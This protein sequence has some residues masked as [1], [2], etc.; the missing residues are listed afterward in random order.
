MGKLKNKNLIVI[1]GLD[2]SGKKTQANL[3]VDNLNSVGKKAVS[4][5]FPVYGSDTS[6]LLKRHLNEGLGKENT[7][8]VSS[9]FALDRYF[10]FTVNLNNKYKDF[11]FIVA[12]RYT[13]SNA[14]YQTAKFRPDSYPRYLSWLFDYEYQKIKNPEPDLVILLAIPLK[15]SGE[16]LLKRYDDDESKKDLYEKDTKYLRLCQK[17]SHSLAIKY[18]WKIVPCF[19]VKNNNLLTPAEISFNVFDTVK[20]YFR[21]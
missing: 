5:S 11:D 3:L 7:Y 12:D 1:E 15:V 9:L 20:D 17:I 18:K 6:S 16:L 2:G 10:N 19:D 8:A 4:I 14:M 13:T 21:M